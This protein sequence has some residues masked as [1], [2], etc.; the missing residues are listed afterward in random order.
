MK[1]ADP[2]LRDMRSFRV[3]DE[4]FAQERDRRR[5]ALLEMLARCI[6]SC[7]TSCATAA[8]C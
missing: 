8:C 4:L 3:G 6:R 5:A 1:T 2:S 7:A